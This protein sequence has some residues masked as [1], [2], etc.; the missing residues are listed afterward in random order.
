M[1]EDASGAQ[2]QHQL[3][4]VDHRGFQRAGE[5]RIPAR[6]PAVSVSATPFSPPFEKLKHAACLKCNFFLFLFVILRKSMHVHCAQTG[7]IQIG[8]ITLGLKKC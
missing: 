8:C 1:A 4:V 7:Q 6:D 2:V 3:P 5:G